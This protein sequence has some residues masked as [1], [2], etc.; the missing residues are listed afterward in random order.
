M[1]LLQYMPRIP[2]A[3]KQFYRWTVI[4]VI[5]ALVLVM[6]L[7][8]ISGFTIRWA[9]TT[10]EFTIENWETAYRTM[11]EKHDAFP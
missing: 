5:F 11:K 8:F 9:F 2:S 10:N 1:I 4:V 6:F 3:I 7:V